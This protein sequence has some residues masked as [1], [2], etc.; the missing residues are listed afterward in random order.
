MTFFFIYCAIALCVA[1]ALIA[2]NYLGERGRYT[3]DDD[4]VAFI[5]LGSAVFWPIAVP[6]W[7]WLFLTD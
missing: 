5:I 4:L 2:D 1:I 6:F 3:A 7:V